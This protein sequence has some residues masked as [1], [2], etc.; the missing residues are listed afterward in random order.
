MKSKKYVIFAKKKLIT[1]KK[2]KS[3]FKLYHKV[4]DHCHYTGKYR[5]AAHNACNLHYK[6]PKRIPIVFHNGT[7]YD[8]HLLIEQLAHDF[9][10]PF[11]CLGENTEKYITF[12]ICFFKKQV[13]I[14]NL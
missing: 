12:S 7:N 9:D 1:D 14:K 5:R 6:I 13:L 10:G 3:T 2:D 11:S 8:F 4:R